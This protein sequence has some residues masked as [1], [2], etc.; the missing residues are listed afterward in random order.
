MQNFIAHLVLYCKNM[1]DV[2]LIIKIGDEF[3]PV[4]Q[5]FQFIGIIDQADIAYYEVI[6]LENLLAVGKMI[7][8]NKRNRLN[9]W[10]DGN[11]MD[12]DFFI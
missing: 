9:D 7:Q 11:I 5:K 3:I 4:T 8:V 10:Y 2:C 1:F 6:K 12:V